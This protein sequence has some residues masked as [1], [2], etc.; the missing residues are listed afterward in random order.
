MHA[1]FWCGNLND[2]SQLGYP[3]VDGR[4]ILK[5]NFEEWRV[6]LWTEFM[7]IRIVF[8]QWRDFVKTVM[9]IRVLYKGKGKFLLLN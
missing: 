9:T 2:T 7:C 4:I 5:C 3:G 8:V 6:A 1:I